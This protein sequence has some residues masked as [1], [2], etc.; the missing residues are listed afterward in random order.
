MKAVDVFE[1]LE[2]YDMCL[3]EFLHISLHVKK[4]CQYTWQ[5]PLKHV[6]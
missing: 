4:G 3:I 2:E 5:R 6:F 1:S